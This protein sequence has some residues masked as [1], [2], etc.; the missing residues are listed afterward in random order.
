MAGP[1]RL[2]CGVSL[3]ERARRSRAVPSLLLLAAVVVL[4]GGCRPRPANQAP[5][6]LYDLVALAG[7]ADRQAPFGVVLFGTPSS[8]RLFESGFVELA[9]GPGG[10]TC[11]W[12]R[13]DARMALV[14]PRPAP[15]T[16]VLDIE[17]FAGIEDQRLRV[18]L[19]D[20]PAADLRLPPGRSRQSF[21][22][23]EAAQAAGRNRLRFEFDRASKAGEHPR[24]RL[25]AAFH[26]LTVLETPDPAL[27]SL[28]VPGAPAPFEPGA[29]DR[30]PSLA[31]VSGTAIRYALKLPA[32][33]ELRFTP[34]THPRS[35]SAAMLR[36]TLVGPGGAER[37]IWKGEGREPAAEVVVPVA[38][39]AGDPVLLGLHVAAG[40]PGATAW[41]SWRAV[42]IVGAGALEAPEPLP[43]PRD[44]KAETRAEAMRKA[45]AGDSVM[46]VILDAATAGHFGCYGYPRRTTPEI[47]RIASEGVLFEDAYTP[48][49]YT[50]AAMASLWTSLHPDQHLDVEPRSANL[51]RARL[52]LPDLLAAAGIPT[53][54]FVA[55]GMA[56]PGFGFDRG[57]SRFE[58]VYATYGVDAAAFR[59]VLPPW[60]DEIGDKRA[61]T[62]VHFREPHWPY[63]PPSPFDTLFGPDG[64]IPKWL[65]KEPNWLVSV[66]NRMTR[67]LPQEVDHV[68]RLYDGNL[69]YVDGE[70][71][72][73]RRSL[74]A[75]GLW[76]RTVL[77]VTSDHGEGLWEH[78]HIGH[79]VQV[80][81]A[82][83]KIPLVI[84]FPRGHGPSGVRVPGLVDLLDVAPTLADL[85][86][87]RGRG[88]SDRLFEGRSLLPMLYGAAGKPALLAR[89]HS[90]R[91]RYGLRE[92]RFKYVFDTGSGREE[93]YDVAADPGETQ[94]VAAEDAVRTAY[95]RQVLQRWLLRLEPQAREEVPATA[96]TPQQEENL[97]ALG[98]VQ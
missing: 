63:D 42:R 85:F 73:L 55:N 44:E 61:F 59:R 93:L 86:G 15:R 36:V 58:E 75:R 87:V 16:A 24:F 18:F 92:R 83:V 52:T 21:A 20:A 3:R 6:V 62:Y 48:A 4:A 22:L 12:S 17:P 13:N 98:Y 72:E 53:G 49:P 26:S 94:D 9:R 34:R 28:L 27:A 88:G 37:E 19:N 77:I 78:G 25:S 39:R 38:A 91:P 45:V 90:A 46:L 69:A 32:G 64:P 40:R 81:E 82:S 89:S 66:D 54:G 23:P 35:R 95:F 50:L 43:V 14:L 60:L 2:E 5:R 51:R 31:Q 71:G 65:R 7:V 56:G 41:A 30:I 96:L 29:E 33:S 8:F 80:Y 79:E 57:F 47:D 1:P 97:K 70:V 67:I 84:R 11:M 10:S 76:D 68:V 74:E